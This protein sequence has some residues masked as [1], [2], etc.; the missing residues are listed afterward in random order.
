MLLVNKVNRKLGTRDRIDIDLQV[1][2]FFFFFAIQLSSC[3]HPI[4]SIQFYY[5]MAFWH[6]FLLS[7][8]WVMFEGISEAT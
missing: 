7:E 3:S 2:L 6:C 4:H 1:L 5:R 8:G